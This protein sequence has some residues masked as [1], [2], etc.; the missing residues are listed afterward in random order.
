MQNATVREYTGRC[1]TVE[2][3]HEAIGPRDRVILERRSCYRRG[4]DNYKESTACPIAKASNNSHFHCC[5]FFRSLFS[6]PVSE[7]FFLSLLPFLI[8]EAKKKF[9]QR[10][11]TISQGEHHVSSAQHS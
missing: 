10:R 1:D 11:L 5:Q 8:L 9:V 7:I 6:Q 4:R 3:I 2:N